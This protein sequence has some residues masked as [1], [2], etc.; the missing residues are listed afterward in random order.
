MAERIILEV[1]GV[2][3]VLFGLREV[4]RDIFHPT[5]SG[6]LSDFNGRVTSVLMRHTPLRASA[7]PIAL[8]ATIAE[9]AAKLLRAVHSNRRT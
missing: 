6:S 7:G 8:V 1:S 9:W 3:V 2:L 5:H 4:F